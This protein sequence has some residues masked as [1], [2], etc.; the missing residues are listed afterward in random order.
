VSAILG[1]YSVNG[2]PVDLADLTRM[3]T[4]LRHRGPDG[5]SVWV[6]GEVGLSHQLLSTAQKPLTGCTIVASRD[7]KQVIV[8]DARIDNRDELNEA[9]GAGSCRSGTTGDAEL[10]LRSYFKWG[11]ECTDKLLGDF[12]F[13]IWDVSH[14]HLFCARDAMGVKPFYYYYQPK[15]IFVFASEIKAL[16]ALQ[17]V[18]RRLNELRVAHYLLSDLNDERAT[19]YRDIFRLP[20]GQS[21]KVSPNG[22]ASRRYWAPRCPAELVLR[23]DDEYA[24]AF[25]DIFSEAVRCRIR[26]CDRVGSMLSGGLD[27]SAIVRVAQKHLAEQ[28]GPRL[29]TFSLIFD[30]V[31][32]CDERSYIRALTSEG[33]LQAHFVPGDNLSPM[34]DSDRVVWHE[35]EP[36]YAPNL[37]LHWSLYAAARQQYV[38]V[39]LDGFDGDTVVS[40]GL[41]RLG[42][43]AR[44]GQWITLFKEARKVSSR[45]RASLW[46][47]IRSYVIRPHAPQYIRQAWRALR[48][49]SRGT[50]QSSAILSAPFRQRL[51]LLRAQIATP[52]SQANTYSSREAHCRELMSELIPLG[53]EVADRAA[54]AFAVE[55]RYPFF[56]RRLVEFCLALPP[57]QKLSSGWTRFIMRRALSN[58]LPKEICWRSTKSDL[59]PNFNRAFIR[60]ERE[61]IERTI[62]SEDGPIREYVDIPE[63][64]QAFHRYGSEGSEH[65]ALTVWRVLT[66][67]VWLRRMFNSCEPPRCLAS[68]HPATPERGADFGAINKDF[69]GWSGE[70]NA[71]KAV[72][73]TQR[74]PTSRRN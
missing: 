4:C 13:A 67:N 30:E 37:F 19:F 56:D 15:E 42:D 24:E 43:L 48:N 51:G 11:Q 2:R 8:A 62:A 52:K 39:L 1:I 27:S 54:A 10:I 6:A 40:H 68:S 59:G 7:R 72:T 45:S 14:R 38:R 55:P 41:G 32:E 26:N 34:V 25:R 46:D 50:R 71:R 5:S 70:R 33:D 47:V 60:F 28:K 16:L 58:L 36:F 31:P 57:Q 17:F 69:Q 9:L 65:D 35:D 20:R 74:S 3:L 63:L 73:S 64:R 18:P 12:S 23:S 49:Y 61:Q 66:L 44:T 29:Q 22:I 53:L 21:I